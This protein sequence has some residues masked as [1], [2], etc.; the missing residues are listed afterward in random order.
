LAER[1]IDPREDVGS[2]PGA[3]PL[4]GRT[5]VITGTLGRS[6]HELK[7]ELERLGAKVVGSVS[8]NTSYLV[9]GENP[10]SK[11]AKAREL[12]V[13]VIGDAELEEMLGS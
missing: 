8:R 7:E 5:F 3:A 10:G 6:R 13:E 12:G 9:A 4:D 1:G 11:L 2:R